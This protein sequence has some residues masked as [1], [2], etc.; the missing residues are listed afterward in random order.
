VNYC[1]QCGQPLSPGAHFCSECGAPVGA[2]TPPGAAQ[3]RWAPP[4]TEAS[5]AG[6]PLGPPG[7]ASPSGSAGTPFA[8]PQPSA[9]PPAFGA[10][11]PTPA[12]DSTAHGFPAELPSGVRYAGFWR[13]F[14][15]LA[16]DRILLGVVLLPVGLLLGVNMFRP[17][18]ND[19]ELRPD[20]LYQV[21]V[22][23]MSLWLVRSFAE[24]AYFST[25]QCS[26]RQ[27]TPGQ[28]ALGLRVTGLDGG[29]IGFGRASGRYFASWL[30]AALLLIGFIMGAFTE[31][32]QTLHDMVASTLVVRG[33]SDP[34]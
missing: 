20:W 16:I 13:R 5:A 8:A 31:R 12:G 18:M 6:V 30:S 22:G 29:R 10:P 32:R 24:W 1:T 33:G 2:P 15:G 23:S 28:M 25:F 11:P 7:P 34:A 19:G 17:L 21:V 27:A 9:A 3:S 14:W 4:A 26:S